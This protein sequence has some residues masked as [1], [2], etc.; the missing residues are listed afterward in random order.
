MTETEAKL[1]LG[2]LSRHIALANR[3]RNDN[4]RLSLSVGVT[5]YDPQR[6]STIAELLVQGDKAMCENKK[7]KKSR[8]K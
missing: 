5:H 8:Q 2:R 1:T 4:A 7:D 3:G 6:P